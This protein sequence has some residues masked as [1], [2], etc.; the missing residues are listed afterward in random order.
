VSC[1]T[2]INC[3]AVGVANVRTLIEHWRGSKWVR[4]KSPNPAVA[5]SAALRSV[6]CLS[7]RACWAVGA[8]VKQEVTGPDSTLAEHWN[9]RR[10]SIVRTP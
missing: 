10:W 6:F 9:G 2:S 1:A 4:V 7:P 8:S 3:F 5:K